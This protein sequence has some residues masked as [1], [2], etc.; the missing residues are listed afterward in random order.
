MGTTTHNSRTNLR[1]HGRLTDFAV[2]DGF[3]GHNFE[4]PVTSAC[5]PARM[6]ASGLIFINLNGGNGGIADGRE[7]GSVS[8]SSVVTVDPTLKYGPISRAQLVE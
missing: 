5:S 3:E 8:S 6:P 1:P 4:L 7:R 2:P